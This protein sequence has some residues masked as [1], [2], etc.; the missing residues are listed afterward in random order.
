M[1]IGW[2]AA[3]SH[4]LLLFVFGDSVVWTGL[5]GSKPQTLL[6]SGPG[7]DISYKSWAFIL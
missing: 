5:N 3:N 1:R 6:G 7:F 2:P 4:R